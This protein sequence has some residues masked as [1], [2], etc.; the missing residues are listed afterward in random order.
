LYYGHLGLRNE[1]KVVLFLLTIS[2]LL[3]FTQMPI[4]DAEGAVSWNGFLREIGLPMLS[5][6]DVLRFSIENSVVPQGPPPGGGAVGDAQMVGFD[7]T[8]TEL[9]Y[10]IKSVPAI[11]PTLVTATVTVND[12]AVALSCTVNAIQNTIVTC[13]ATGSIPV[14][15]SDIVRVV[16]TQQVLNGLQGNRYADL[17]ISPSSTMTVGGVLQPTDTT[18]L[19][20]GY[21]VLNAY[22][23]APTAVGI[24]LGIYLVKR[25]F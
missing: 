17:Y 2:A 6:D 5:G 1:I 10:R 9:L 14:Q 15:T 12:V 24:G 4:Q 21:S 7:G 3:G 25:K 18:A 23:I 8:I 19:I 11:G 22:W 20:I 16:D 13:S